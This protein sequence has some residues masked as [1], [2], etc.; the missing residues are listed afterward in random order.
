LHRFLAQLVQNCVARWVQCVSRSI[1]SSLVI[2]KPPISPTSISSQVL[3]PGF[4]FGVVI[5]VGLVDAYARGVRLVLGLAL[6]LCLDFVF[7]L[8]LLL[9]FMVGSLGP[10]A[11]LM[12]ANV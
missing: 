4:R 11:R 7:A 10:L 5:E 12:I 9:A 6:V 2:P 8:L 3:K 1:R